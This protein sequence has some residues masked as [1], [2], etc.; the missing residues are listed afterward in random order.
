MTDASKSA[1]PPATPIHQPFSWLHSSLEGRG[2]AEFLAL[3]KTVCAGVVTCLQLA[4]QN[5]L[6][7]DNG[8]TPLMNM[9][10]SEAL[11]ML[12]TASAH[13]LG[14]APEGHIDFMN[15]LAM[16]EAAA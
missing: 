6:A 7:R 5:E 3:T 9:N 13:L 15:G 14:S 4:Q 2:D 8:R 12:A 11:L 10:D 16:K 1:I